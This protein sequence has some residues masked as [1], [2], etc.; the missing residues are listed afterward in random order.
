MR[1]RSFLQR[2][3]G[4][5][6]LPLVRVPEAAAAEPA[7]A[8]APAPPLARPRYSDSD[9]NTDFSSLSDRNR[10]SGGITYGA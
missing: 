7:P 4:T 2:A 10:T 6:F 8:P 5:L 3:L 9:G 1:R